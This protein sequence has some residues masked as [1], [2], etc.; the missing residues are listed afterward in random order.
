[1]LFLQK[2]NFTFNFP[3][4][5]LK[6]NLLRLKPKAK[7]LGKIYV[8]EENENCSLKI[9]FFQIFITKRNF[10]SCG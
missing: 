4:T 3:K 2:K 1:M 10:E 8:T 9:F 5:K 6:F 7:I